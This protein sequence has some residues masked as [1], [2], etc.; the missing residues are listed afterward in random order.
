MHLGRWLLKNLLAGMGIGLLFILVH[1]REMP[2]ETLYEQQAREA[3]PLMPPTP[4]LPPRRV[5]IVAGHAGGNDPGAV[6]PDG[7]TEV[8]VNQAVARYVKTLL[9]G[10]G[11][12]V[13][14][15][16]EFDP[17]LNG[18]RALA[19]VSIH[20]DSCTLS[21]DLSGFKLAVSSALVRSG[22]ARR[23]LRATRL[24]Q[25]LADWY[26]AETG[27]FFHKDTVTPDMTEYHAFEEI[28]PETPAVII[29]VGFLRGDYDLLVHHPKIPARG[30]AQGVLCFARTQGWNVLPL[31]KP[32]TTPAPNRP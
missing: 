20:A 1:P 31:P 6:C 4:T 23:L 9:E 18:Y 17:R 5:G 25:C 3:T 30:I 22:E 14:V 28:H 12:T 11:F 26:Q 19:L 8:Q 10:Q 2:R 24:K 15:L 7:V 16:E 13:D 32:T 27:L 21:P 29:E